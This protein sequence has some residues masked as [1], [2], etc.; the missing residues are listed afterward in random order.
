MADKSQ[1]VIN[2]D[3]TAVLHWTESRNAFSFFEDDIVDTLKEVLSMSEEAA[4]N[5]CNGTET[6][7]TSIAQR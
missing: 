3:K 4:K 2:K 1:A 6:V 7:E 5:W